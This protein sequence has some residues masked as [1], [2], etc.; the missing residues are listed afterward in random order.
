MCCELLHRAFQCLK[1]FHIISF[2]INIDEAHIK[3]PMSNYPLH[4]Y[5]LKQ[6]K[7]NDLTSSNKM[8]A[9]KQADFSHPS[10]TEN[11]KQTYSAQ[12]S[13]MKMRQ[14]LEP[15]RS[16]KNIEGNKIRLPHL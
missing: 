13:D 7:V 12:N 8:V 2:S 11:K 6:R 3:I 16:E 15:P 10:I 14:F 1:Y 9:Q 4:I 5:K